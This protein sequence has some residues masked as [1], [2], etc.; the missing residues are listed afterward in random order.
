METK[1]YCKKCDTGINGKPMQVRCSICKRDFA[2]THKPPDAICESCAKKMQE[3]DVFRC[4]V[5]SENI[6]SARPQDED[7]PE[8]K[9]MTRAYRRTMTKEKKQ[10]D[11]KMN[12][13]ASN[14]RKGKNGEYIKGGERS[15]DVRMQKMTSRKNSRHS[16]KQNISRCLREGFTYDDYDDIVGGKVKFK[17]NKGFSDY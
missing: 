11:L 4:R 14:G 2:S 10:R 5:C 3:D 15:E 17:K 8:A 1:D 13:Y 16:D 7:A 12:F 6:D 9:D